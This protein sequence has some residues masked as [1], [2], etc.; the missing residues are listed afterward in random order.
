MSRL[1]DKELFN[2]YFSKVSNKETINAL[3]TLEH[4][5]ELINHLITL[6]CRVQSNIDLYKNYYN[7]QLTTNQEDELVNSYRELTLH[8]LKDCAIIEETEY[9]LKR[10]LVMKF[11]EQAAQ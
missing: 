6:L 10:Y 8:F 3:D 7:K 11:L 9:Q 4:C 5:E 2:Y 1:D